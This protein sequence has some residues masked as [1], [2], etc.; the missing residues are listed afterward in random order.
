LNCQERENL[1]V[2]S[3]NKSKNWSVKTFNGTYVCH[4]EEFVH[5]SKS[6]GRIKSQV[7]TANILIVAKVQRGPQQLWCRIVLKKTL[8]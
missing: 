5:P 6:F 3:I 4:K 1:P 2:P 7:K 8:M